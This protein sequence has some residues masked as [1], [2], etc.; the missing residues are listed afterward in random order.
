MTV[1]VPKE[2]APGERRVAL[3]PDVVR[4]LKGKGV[5]VV[6][7]AGAGAEAL[8]PDRLY[9]DAGATIGDPWAADVVAKVAPPTPR[10]GGAPARATPSSSASWRR[11]RA[12]VDPRRWP[13]RG[14]TAFAMEAIPRISR[15]Q[16]MDALSSQ[17]NV[18]RLQGRAARRRARHALLPDA[19][20]RGGHDPA[21]Q[22]AGAGRRRRRPAGA[23]HRPAPGRADHG[24]RRAP[25][26]RRAGPVARRTWLDLGI[27]AAGEGGYARELTDEERAQ[28]QQA[29][30]EAIQGFDVVITTALVPGRPAP[31]LV[32]AEAVSGMK[33][34][35]VIVDLAG[36]TGGNCELTVP[37][38]VTVVHDVTIVSP[39]NLPASMPE[40]ASQLYARNIAALLE[41]LV[42]EDGRAAPRL[43]RRDRRRRV[44]HARRRDRP[45]A[46]A[47]ASRGGR[48][49]MLVPNLADPRAG[50]LRRLRG[51]LQGPEHAAH[52]ADV[53][54]ERDPRHRRARRH[55]RARPRRRRRRSTRCCSSSRSPSARSTSSAASSSPTGCSR[56]SRASPRAEAAGE[57]PRRRRRRPAATFLHDPDFI[58]VLYIVAFS[59][60]I[61]GLSGLRARRP[62]CAAT[63][64][65]RRHGRRGRR[66]VPHRRDGQLGPHRARHRRS[67]R[68]SASP[69][70]AT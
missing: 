62:R 33:P 2:T 21:G 30:T 12:R 37:G 20:D 17:S 58:A 70:R 23:G 24:L 26:G 9:E 39:L 35:S 66:D 43:R 59:L 60:F 19:H 64:R 32:T 11:S 55:H 57:E 22:G 8:I 34:G 25:R 67:A 36:E 13:R 46:G 40:H 28:Q 49:L 53:G 69:R 3:V 41:L 45:P 5:D 51:H 54:H 4:R 61:Y 63:D 10:R 31:R 42:G 29:L 38:E 27:E 52:A 1:G 50:R 56:C 6:V 48:V 14:I 15:A 16:A 47:K 65:R 7:E 18:S 68:S 44:R